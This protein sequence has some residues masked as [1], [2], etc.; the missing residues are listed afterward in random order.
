MMKWQTDNISTVCVS[1]CEP[2]YHYLCLQGRCEDRPASGSSSCLS[3]QSLACYCTPN[4][5]AATAAASS[6]S[7]A[8]WEPRR[9]QTHTQ[10]DFR[11]LKSLSTPLT[12]QSEWDDV[13]KGI[14]MRKSR[15]RQME[16]E[17]EDNLTL[18]G[19]VMWMSTDTGF[20]LSSSSLSLGIKHRHLKK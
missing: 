18:L 9:T 17:N 14:S 5:S 1:A 13:L 10:L 20:S 3:D 11:S 16:R 4:V 6:A 2:A 7:P 19:S 15:Q 12:Q 8:Y